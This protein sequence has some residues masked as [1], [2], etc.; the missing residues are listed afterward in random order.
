M[1]QRE[2]SIHWF[3]APECPQQLDLRQAEARSLKLIAGFRLE[4]QGH[5][6]ISYRMLPL[7]L[8]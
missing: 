2:I 5:N 8:Y 1:S 7:N 6:H 3:V 4:W